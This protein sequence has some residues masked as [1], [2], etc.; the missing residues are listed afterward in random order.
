MTSSRRTNAWFSSKEPQN[1][2]D[3]WICIE[4]DGTITAKIYNNG[5]WNYI[6]APKSE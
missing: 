2:N 4:E 6:L 1:K 3:I 5:E